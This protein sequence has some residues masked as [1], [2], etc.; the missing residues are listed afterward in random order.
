[1]LLVA[2][3]T[4]GLDVKKWLPDFRHYAKADFRAARAKD[5]VDIGDIPAKFGYIGAF[6]MDEF[7]RQSQG[8]FEAEKGRRFYSTIE[9]SWAEQREYLD[10]ALAALSSD[11]REEA[12]RAFAELTPKPAADTMDAGTPLRSLESC[13]SGP[14]ELVFAENGGLVG[15]TDDSGR[16]WVEEADPFGVYAYET[17]GTED[18]ERYFRTY[19]QNLPVTHPWA[20]ADFGKPGFEFVR[21]RPSHRVY[22]PMLDDLRVVRGENSDRYR[23]RLRMP[24]EAHESY[25]APKELELE[26]EVGLRTGEIGIVLQWFGKEANRLPEASWFR[27][28]LRTD[29]PNLWTMEKLGLPLSPLRVVQGGNRNLHAVG[30]GVRYEGA[31]GTAEIE[32]LD[33]AL[34]APGCGR[35][36]QFDGTFAPLSSGWHFNLHNNIWGTNFP[37]WYGEDARFRFRLRLA[38]HRR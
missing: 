19:M 7:D 25:G 23:L 22:L 21:P 8:K 35:L 3:H 26:Y 4:W 1:M 12:L 11:K 9:R 14:Y 32:T 33:A 28:G 30:S 16:R 31:D 17:F 18:Y 13:R 2:E 34:A 29:N 37:M 27:C 6:A 36:L 5:E 20:D 24:A 15:L 10:Q 38:S